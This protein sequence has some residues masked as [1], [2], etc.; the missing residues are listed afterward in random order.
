MHR[1]GE[2]HGGRLHLLGLVSDG[3]VHSSLTHL[4]A[5]IDAAHAS[6]VTV[7]V[8]AFLD[9][10]DVQPGTAPEYLAQLERRSSRG[11]GVIGTVAGRY[12]AMD[13]DNRWERVERP[14]KRDRRTPTRRR[15]QD[16]RREGIEAIVRRGEDRRVRRAVRRR[17]LRGR[18]PGEGRG[19]ALQLPPRP[20]AR[21]HARARDS[22]T[23]RLRARRAIAPFSRVRVHDDVRRDARPADRVSEGDV[24]PT[25]SRRS[26]R[27]RGSRSSAARRRRSTRT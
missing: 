3:G 17:R 12:W 1:D 20:R 24:S 16:A 15:V 6:G 18:R 14:I 19:A 23:S 7:V 11:K 13:R 9:G 21:A 5:L 22:R 27:A 10:R 25:S 2:A 4:L 26:S 8:H